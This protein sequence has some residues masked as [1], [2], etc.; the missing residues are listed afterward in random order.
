MKTWSGSGSRSVYIHR[1]LQF[2]WRKCEA[3]VQQEA[4]SA[5][6]KQPGPSTSRRSEEE[7]HEEERLKV[8]IA[9]EEWSD[10]MNDG[11]VSLGWDSHSHVRPDWDK[12]HTSCFSMLEKKRIKVG[13]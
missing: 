7:L 6:I 1:V 9:D 8:F 4:R 5:K 11:F 12:R 3:G 10:S 2:V 13:F